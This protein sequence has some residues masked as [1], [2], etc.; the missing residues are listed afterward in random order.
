MDLH[1]ENDSA[2][3]QLARAALSS[4]VTLHCDDAGKISAGLPD[5]YEMFPRVA[6]F[7]AA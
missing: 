6:E 1:G 5:R 3:F 4:L 2:H 7:P